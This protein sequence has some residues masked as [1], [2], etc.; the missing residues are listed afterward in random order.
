MTEGGFDDA[1]VGVKVRDSG[2]AGGGAAGGLEDFTGTV[3]EGLALAL[4]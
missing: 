3:G 2:V 4:V 1:L